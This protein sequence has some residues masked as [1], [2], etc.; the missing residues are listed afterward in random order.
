MG[1]PRH[2]VAK[3]RSSGNIRAVTEFY[4]FDRANA[5]LPELRETLLRLHALREE[6]IAT[7]D[8][9]VELNAPA[10]TGG[11]VPAALPDREAAEETQRLRMRMQGL[12][13][14]MQAAALQIDAWG[15]QLR[16][17]ATG[18]VDFPALVSGR[19]VWLCWRLD[20]DSV[21][22]WHEVSEGFDSR[23]RIEDLF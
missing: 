18:L 17:I 8:R 23:R 15:I 9:I 1:R 22:W 6:V 10:L 5:R 16:E 3:Y 11:A 2:P 7:R 12:V 4:D 13:D 14:Q 19:P 20:E 21:G